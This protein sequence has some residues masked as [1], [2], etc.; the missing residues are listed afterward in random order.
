MSDDIK[1]SFVKD[2]TDTPGGGLRSDGPFSGQEFFEDI[3]EPAIQKVIKS[4]NNCFVKIDFEGI[5]DYSIDFI[6]KSFGSVVKAWGKEGKDSICC[7]SYLD[8][9]DD[10]E[11]IMEEAY[12]LTDECKKEEEEYK[13]YQEFIKS[14]PEMSN[15]EI[16]RDFC[17]IMQNM[18][19]HGSCASLINDD[20]GHWAISG[21]GIQNVEVGDGPINLDTTFFLEAKEFADTIPE[22]LRMWA[23]DGE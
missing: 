17:S 11:N 4:G 22:A 15:E 3:L 7:C 16:N 20:S 12:E 8:I 5:H 2:F 9:D 19:K 1:I 21:N 18:M 6:K 13:Q 23:R 10:V 14:I